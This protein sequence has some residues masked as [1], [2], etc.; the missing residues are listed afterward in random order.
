MEI[1]FSEMFVYLVNHLF[2]EF[3]IFSHGSKDLLHYSKEV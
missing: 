2:Y 3:R 1:C